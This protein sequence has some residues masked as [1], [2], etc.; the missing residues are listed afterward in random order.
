M[1]IITKFDIGDEVCVM[2]ADKKRE[3]CPVCDGT[4]ELKCKGYKFLC[5]RCDGLGE[6]DSESNVGLCFS[7]Q[8]YKIKGFSIVVKGTGEPQIRYNL[9]DYGQ[10]DEN[11]C[12]NPENTNIWHAVDDYPKQGIP[13]VVLDR[14]LT[15]HDNHT[16]EGHAYYEFIYDDDGSADGYRSDVDIIAWRYENVEELK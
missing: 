13:I 5:P 1:E 10:A 11:S 9:S 3:K 12:I 14:D 2:Q 7:I 4:G 6:I 16:W 15:E 8:S